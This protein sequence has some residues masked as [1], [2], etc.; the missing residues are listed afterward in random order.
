[1]AAR[2]LTLEAVAW[3]VAGMCLEDTRVESVRVR[4]DKP[5]ALRNARGAAVVLRRQSEDL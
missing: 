5:G 4:V 3:D 2:R 1:M